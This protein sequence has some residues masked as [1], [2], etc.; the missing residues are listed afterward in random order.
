MQINVDGLE[1]AYG[2]TRAVDHI[3]FQFSSG[4]IVGF[5]GPNGAGKTTTIKVM[6]T[7]ELPDAGDVW[8]DDISAVN[9]PELVRQLIGYMPDSLP[10]YRDIEVWEYLDFFARSFGLRGARRTRVLA[11][12]E[13]FTN[14]GGMR[15]KY[16]ASL[17]KGMKQRVSMARALVHNPEVLIMD[18]PAAGLDPRARLE[19]PELLKILA[20][21]GKAILLSSHI[22]S[23]LQDICDSAVI[24]ERGR[25]R[26]AG[27]LAE[28]GRRIAVQPDG[29]VVFGLMAGVI[30]SIGQAE[31]MRQTLLTHPAVAMAAA[32]DDDTVRI[33]VD[34]DDR[35]LSDVVGMLFGSGF[36]I[37]SFHKEEMG[38][39]EIF[40]KVTTGEV[41]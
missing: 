41:Q 29:E 39:E 3:G 13:E 2:K 15:H 11:D 7:L 28:M 14:L 4:Q 22:L 33:E 38:L 25:I 6:S 35:M 31:I 27:T 36:T 8:Y 23:E 19:L 5:I 18:E 1:R 16:L 17:S 40:M 26:S 32:L 9:Y 37:S 24:I 34:G 10:E 30:R 20:G 21:Q 12:I